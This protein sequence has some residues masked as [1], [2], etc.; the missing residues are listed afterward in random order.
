MKNI[1]KYILEKLYINEKKSISKIAKELKVSNGTIQYG[2]K[3]FKIK[4]RGYS[5]SKRLLIGRGIPNFDKIKKN[6]WKCLA[7]ALDCEG[8]IGFQSYKTLTPAINIA[9]SSKKFINNI[10]K[11]FPELFNKCITRIVEWKNYEWIM[12]N[13]RTNS[14]EYVF[15]T[16][17]RIIPY[18]TTKKN[19]A[20]LLKKFCERRSRWRKNNFKKEDRK[21][22]IELANFIKRMNMKRQT[23]DIKDKIFIEAE[24]FIKINKL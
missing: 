24:E 5:E 6:N 9:M 10:D 18:L 3:K 2:L 11:E 14:N 17:K 7:W 22:D 15:K 20:I 23:D 21:I 12:Y 1:N 4:G 13:L 8:S 16:L 19:I